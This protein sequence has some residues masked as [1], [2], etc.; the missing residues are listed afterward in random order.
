V[1]AS[2]LDALDHALQRYEFE[3]AQVVLETLIASAS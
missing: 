1:P 2:Q 3:R